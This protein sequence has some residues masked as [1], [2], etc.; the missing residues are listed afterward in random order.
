MSILISLTIESSYERELAC[1]TYYSGENKIVHISGVDE[2]TTYVLDTIVSD[3]P[4]APADRAH[5][6]RAWE[7]WGRE[8]LLQF[9]VRDRSGDHILRVTA[10]SLPTVAGAIFDVRLDATGACETTV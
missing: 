8:I 3:P 2:V 9:A 10:S 4:V 1:A 7:E 5:D 6:G